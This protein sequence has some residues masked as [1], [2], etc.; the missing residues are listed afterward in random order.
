MDIPHRRLAGFATL[1]PL[2]ERA[3]THESQ[4]AWEPARMT[5][6]TRDSQPGS[7]A[8]NINGDTC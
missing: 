3:G 7:F 6:G 1:I 2:K 4:Q 5:A 8:L